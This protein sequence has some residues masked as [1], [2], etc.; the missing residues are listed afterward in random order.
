MEGDNDEND[1][2]NKVIFADKNYSENVLHL[3]VA[4][5]N[6]EAGKYYN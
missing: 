3:I 6:S 4:C 5:E 2:R 1:N